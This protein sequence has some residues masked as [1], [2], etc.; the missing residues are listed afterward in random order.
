MRCRQIKNG[1][2]VWFN[3]LGKDSN[4][5]AIKA[6]N[7]V[8]NEKAVASSL[9]QRLSVLKKELWYRISYG[10]PLFEKVKSKVFMD[11]EITQIIM[12]HPEVSRIQSFSSYIINREYSYDCVIITTYGEIKLNSKN[13]NM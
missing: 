10:L 3:S 4:D 11:S 9:I 5:L 13:I 2:V 1:E 12:S 7:F 6:D 8:E